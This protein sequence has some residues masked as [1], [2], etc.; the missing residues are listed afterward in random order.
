MIFLSYLTKH[1][2]KADISS[3]YF[4]KDKKYLL[5]F[6]CHW[7]FVAVWASSTCGC[8]HLRCTGFSW[9][10]PL[11]WGAEALGPWSSVGTARGLRS[12]GAGASCSLA[13]G[14]CPDQG[15]N[16]RPLNQTDSQPR[17]LATRGP[18]LSYVSKPSSK[19]VTVCKQLSTC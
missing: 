15:S 16:L 19:E 14:I 1:T 12:C 8:L 18:L 4:L 5:I 10:W 17:I 6:S 11:H 2:Q 3:H 13:R 9:Q 7:V